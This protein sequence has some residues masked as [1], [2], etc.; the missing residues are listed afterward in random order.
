MKIKF[1]LL[2]ITLCL[3]GVAQAQTIKYQCIFSSHARGKDVLTNPSFT[4]PQDNDNII[5]VN[6]EEDYIKLYGNDLI[7]YKILSLDKEINDHATYYDM[8]SID[9]YGNNCYIRLAHLKN[10]S[11]DLIY[12][13]YNEL[14]V[15]FGCEI[16]SVNK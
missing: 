12:I 13:F 14:T 2:F 8:S 6:F 15:C 3:T 4:M 11:Y 10:K 9:S 7:K 5:I 16:I 1:L